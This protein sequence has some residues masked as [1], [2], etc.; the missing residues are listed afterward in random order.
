MLDLCWPCHTLL[1]CGPAV[2]VVKSVVMIN[3]HIHYN[4][5]EYLILP[6]PSPDYP[7]VDPLINVKQEVIGTTSLCRMSRYIWRS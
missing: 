2:A 1:M 5:L 7:V 3:L 6:L 4:S